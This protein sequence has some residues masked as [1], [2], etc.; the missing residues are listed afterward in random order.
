MDFLVHGG[1]LFHEHKPS[2]E[3]L[4]KTGQLLTQHVFGEKEHSFK[5]AAPQRLNIK[6]GNLSIKLPIFAIHGNHDDPGGM[7]NLSNIDILHS[8][9]LVSRSCHRRSTISD[10][11]IQ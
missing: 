7:D 3:T 10:A 5:V 6:D 11:P 4:I 8:T 1:D 9:K 2:K